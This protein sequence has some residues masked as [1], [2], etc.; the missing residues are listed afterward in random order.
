[1]EQQPE[2][3]RVGGSWPKPGGHGLGRPA[4]ERDAERAS[5]RCTVDMLVLGAG[6]HLGARGGNLWSI[7]IYRGSALAPLLPQLPWC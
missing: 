7:S 3:T 2:S 4:L 1:M 6:T 5:Q